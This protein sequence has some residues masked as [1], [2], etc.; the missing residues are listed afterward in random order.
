MIRSLL[1]SL[2]QLSIAET[3]GKA[4]FHNSAPFWQYLLDQFRLSVRPSVK[5]AS[6]R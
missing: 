2:K 6:C 5:S 1:L 4:M 3:Y